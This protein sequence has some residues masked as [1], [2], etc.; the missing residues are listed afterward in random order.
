MNLQSAENDVLALDDRMRRPDKTDY[1]TPDCMDTMQRIDDVSMVSRS[2]ERPYRQGPKSV[3]R[4]GKVG[5]VSWFCFD[6][7][8]L[9]K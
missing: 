1:N 2:E 9:P 5:S 7:D 6:A 3:D 8:V 4:T